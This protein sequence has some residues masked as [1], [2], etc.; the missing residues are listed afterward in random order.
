MHTP[1]GLMVSLI[2]LCIYF[3]FQSV[4]DG[5]L[6]NSHFLGSKSN[7]TL[8]TVDVSDPYPNTLVLVFPLQNL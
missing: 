6:S 1:G 5:H 3:L 8:T 4:A 7:P 2:Y